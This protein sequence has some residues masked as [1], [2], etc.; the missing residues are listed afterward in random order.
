M[1]FHLT[2]ISIAVLLINGFVAEAQA[3]SVAIGKINREAEQVTEIELPATK[4]ERI[5]AQI[6]VK[7]KLIKSQN[8]P[9]IGEMPG[10]KDYFKPVVVRTNTTRTEI[11]DISFEFQ[12]RLSTPFVDPKIIDQSKADIQKDGQSVY[13]KPNDMKPFT[14]FVTGS[15]SNDPVVSL[16]LVPKSIPSQVILLQTDKSE[17][18]MQMTE[19]DRPTSESYT[20]NVR[21]IFRQMALGKIPAG[22]SEAPLPR[23]V[24]AIRGLVVKPMTR[25]SGPAADIYAYRIEGTTNEPVDL[26]ENSFMQK[27]V[28]AVSFFPTGTVRRGVATMAYIFA[29]KVEE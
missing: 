1:K 9:G 26:Q 13:I 4:I 10:R 2:S 15:G 7:P 27:G 24:A 8:L 6:R 17:M 19:E 12:N 16:T 14:I 23:S 22:Y 5:P 3:Q 29:T 25:F 18:P 11:I 20:E 21:Y 28:R